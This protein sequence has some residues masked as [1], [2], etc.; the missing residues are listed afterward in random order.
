MQ[1]DG[2][3]AETLGE[4]PVSLS[5]HS[6]I[7]GHETVQRSHHHDILQACRADLMEMVAVWLRECHFTPI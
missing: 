4:D 3:R 6:P 1:M 7:K 2:R 5:I